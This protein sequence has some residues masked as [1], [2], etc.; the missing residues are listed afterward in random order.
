MR[1]AITVFRE[2]V[3]KAARAFAVTYHTVREIDARTMEI[4]L[5]LIGRTK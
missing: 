3:A 2:E 5:A 1:T 4:L